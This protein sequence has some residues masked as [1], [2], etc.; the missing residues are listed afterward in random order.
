MLIEQP[1]VDADVTEEVA[2]LKVR[3]TLRTPG[4]AD[5]LTDFRTVIGRTPRAI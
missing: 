2:A 3:W 5:T 1:S 4:T